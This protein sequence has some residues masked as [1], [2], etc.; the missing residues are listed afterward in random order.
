M[1]GWA[2]FSNKARQEKKG[3]GKGKDKG[4]LT[5]LLLTQEARGTHA[6]PPCLSTHFVTTS[7]PVEG[8]RL[9]ATAACSESLFALR[10]EELGPGPRM[11]SDT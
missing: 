5:G 4:E 7:S 3:E 2:V 8:F 9:A 11:S 1:D 6:S 10:S